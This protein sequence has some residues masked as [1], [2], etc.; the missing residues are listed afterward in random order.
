MKASEDIKVFISQRDSKCD[1]CGEELGRQAW[2]TL[3]E[4]NDLVKGRWYVNVHTP[5]NPSGEIRGQLLAP[6]ET[7]YGATLSGAS[8]LPP[9][10]SGVAGSG[11]FVLSADQTGLTYQ[12]SLSGGAITAAQIQGGSAKSVGPVVYPLQVGLGQTFMGVYDSDAPPTQP[13]TERDVAMLALGNWNLNVTTAQFRDGAA[14][15]QIVAP[16]Q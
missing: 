5:T 10:S 13:V 3:E 12:L 6:G 15:G 2:I 7:L 16:K 9:V 14:R 8:E 1:E 4:G 11:Q